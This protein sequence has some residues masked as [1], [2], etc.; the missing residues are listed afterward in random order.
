MEEGRKPWQELLILV[1]ILV[2]FVYAFIN[3]SKL[4]NR[5]AASPNL[6]SNLNDINTVSSEIITVSGKT[7]S[8][9]TL[10]LNGNEIQKDD[11]GNFSTTVNLS[12]GEN[13]ITLQAKNKSGKVSTIE[14][15]VIKII[16]QITTTTKANIAVLPTQNTDD[17]TASGP[18][19]N[20]GILGLAAIILSIFIYSRSTK[21]NQAN[22]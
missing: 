8:G 11:D 12:N 3:V 15:T 22:Y 16:T 21:R 9:A 19:E 6:T 1:I 14:K 17:L 20:A 5:F 10:T 13:K 7:D 2:I 4:Q 18:V